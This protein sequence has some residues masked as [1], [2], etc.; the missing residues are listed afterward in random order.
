M[1]KSKARICFFI[2]H[3]YDKQQMRST[4]CYPC[5]RCG[6]VGDCD[7]GVPCWIREN[8]YRMRVK[9]WSFWKW[10]KCSN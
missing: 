9:L 1:N 5:H 3:L 2:G 6:R 10:L 4:D 7:N 8:K